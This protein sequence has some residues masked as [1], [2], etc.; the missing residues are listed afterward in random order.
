MKKY[1]ISPEGKFYK[2][3]LHCHTTISDGRMTPEEVKAYYKERGYSVVAFTDHCIMLPHPEL[4]DDSFIA[5]NGYENEQLINQKEPVVRRKDCHVCYIALKQDNV[6]MPYYSPKSIWGNGKLYKEQV[7]FNTDE[8]FETWGY[9]A[10]ITNRCMKLAREAGFFVTYNHPGWSAEHYEDYSKYTGMNAMEIFNYGSWEAG[11]PDYV[12]HVYDEFLRSGKRIYAIATDD[13]HSVRNSCG[14]WTMIK[15]PKFEYEAI[16]DALVRGDFYASFG[17][18]IHELW[19]EGNEVHVTCS[20]AKRVI[21][22]FPDRRCLMANKEDGQ[23]VTEAVCTVDKAD[24]YFRI[25]VV[26]END[27][28]ADTNAYFTDEY[29][30]E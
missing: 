22:S 25:T 15:A 1:L 30:T 14:G 24:G 16:T 9:N 26:D 19:I 21:C 4:N 13:N 2:A 27:R 6:T 17:P 3:N 12:P 11:Y 8:T 28:C 7:K 10:D 23:P 20:D 29:L 18:E 5:L